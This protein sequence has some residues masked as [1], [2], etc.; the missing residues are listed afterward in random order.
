MVSLIISFYKNIP[1][2]DLILKSLGRQSCKDFEVII[3]EDADNKETKVFLDEQRLKYF[4]H[5]EHVWHEDVAFR[6]TKINNDA[7]KVS[8]SEKL[9]FIDGDCVLHSKFIETYNTCIEEGKYF[10]GRRVML[11]P[12]I[13]DK[14][15][16]SRNLKYFNLP[17]LLLSD[18]KEKQEALYIPFR[19]SRT[20]DSREIWGCNWG[21]LKK[22]L[23]GVNG[24]DEDYTKPCFGEDLDVGW[25]LKAQFGLKLTS[26][27]N[28]AIQYHLHHPMNWNDLIEAQGRII[29]DK[30]RM[31]GNAVCSN[32]IKKL[33]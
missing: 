12:K 20:N 4:F 3:A 23:V 18:S 28:R 11:G 15:Y 1:A 17:R 9:V 14:L 26:L 6:K 32:G 19:R 33:P 16:A 30:K 27:K 7:V 8:K 13:T 2:L 10:Y 31:A 5:I 24:F 25:R 21:V 29:F 22:Y